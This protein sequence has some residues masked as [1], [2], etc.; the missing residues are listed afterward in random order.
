MGIISVPRCLK[1]ELAWTIDK[2]L[3]VIS[4]IMLFKHAVITGTKESSSF[5]LITIL[6]ALLL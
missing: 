3:Q 2:Q 4:N 5:K 6:Y 1:A